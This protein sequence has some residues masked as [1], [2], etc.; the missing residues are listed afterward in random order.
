MV[1]KIIKLA[2]QE[3]VTFAAD[4]QEY[5]SMLDNNNVMHSLVQIIVLSLYMKNYSEQ[6]SYS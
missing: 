2:D 5:D 3:S 6:V 1:I 4:S